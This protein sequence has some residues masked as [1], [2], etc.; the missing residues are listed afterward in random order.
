MS[1]FAGARFA[2]WLLVLQMSCAA[3]AG[4]PIAHVEHT[5]ESTANQ[6]G[7]NKIKMVAAL[8]AANIV[9][10]Q[11]V[12]HVLQ[13]VELAPA[14]LGQLDSAERAELVG[15][16]KAAKVT[17]GDRFRVLQM[18]AAGAMGSSS[19]ACL[20]IKTD[21][22]TVLDSE[23]RALQSAGG[24]GVSGDSIALMVTALLGVGSFI[25]QAVTEKRAARASE[26]LQRE[27]DRE[28]AAREVTRNTV[29]AQLERVR[30]QMAE[31]L[32]P[33]VIHISILQN[34]ME[35][36][37]MALNMPDYLFPGGGMDMGDILASPPGAPHVIFVNKGVVIAAARPPA[38]P[39]AAS[40]SASPGLPHVYKLSADDAVRLE[41]DQELRERWV[42]TWVS[43]EPNLSAIE[44]IITTKYHL[45]E[46]VDITILDAGVGSLDLGCG[47]R[48]MFL[49]SGTLAC[50]FVPWIR[51]WYSMRERWDADD[52]SQLEPVIP[53]LCSPMWCLIVAM[54]NICG[55]REMALQGASSINSHS[56]TTAAI[57]M[58]SEQDGEG[59][60]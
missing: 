50:T 36:V 42:E 52:Y 26:T 49:S 47:W 12:A 41:A 53:G 19:S 17:L 44:E 8:S 3:A 51:Q 34:T 10:P 27:L 56:G 30:L 1:A 11:L 33:L 31:Y 46:P 22:A 13:S 6:H 60:T 48:D 5:N 57:H 21:T 35:Y 23:T 37:C 40:P 54:S 55:M 29:G 59:D 39:S 14:E 25:V 45:S 18:S 9:A 16:M 43:L 24:G 38:R 7:F 15:A 2:G 20:E 28:L 32:R 4:A 58:A